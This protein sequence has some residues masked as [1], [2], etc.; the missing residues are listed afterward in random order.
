V[1]GPGAASRT[2]QA[3]LAPAQLLC[4]AGLACALSPL[5]LGHATPLAGA[6]ATAAAGIGGGY[7]AGIARLRLAG[8]RGRRAAAL[9][10]GWA[11]VGFVLARL[12]HVPP[13][14]ATWWAI[15]GFAFAIQ[16]MGTAL[17][18]TEESARALAARTVLAGAAAVVFAAFRGPGLLP[19]PA[20]LALAGLGAAAVAHASARALYRGVEPSRIARSA[21]AVV[22][23]LAALTLVLVLTPVLGWIAAGLQDLLALFGLAVAAVM[24]PL[25]YGLLWL[26]RLF[27][28]PHKPFKPTASGPPH[29][30]H[31][32]TGA[33]V[34]HPVAAHVLTALVLAGAAL[35]VILLVARARRP[36]APVDD[37]LYRDEF[38]PP[39][40]VRRRRRA[41]PAAP[42]PDGVR[43]A[44]A[45]ALG[46]LAQASDPRLQ[47]APAETPARVLARV[48]AALGDASP[49][50]QAFARLTAA[51]AAARYARANERLDGPV[52]A[53]ARALRAVV[54][55]RAA[56]A[57]RG[58]G[59]S[60]GPDARPTP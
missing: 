41:A 19:A 37:T 38:L 3:L 31:T 17:V 36:A 43:R 55:T 50:V 29:R 5:F 45:L 13:G 44:Y 42:P 56:A 15:A 35:A 28:H 32:L 11:A 8:E 18:E 59:A 21:G 22:A 47:P 40:A 14:S 49:A 23:V 39:D 46:V 57:R 6:V 34:A 27:A 30:G 60:S 58:R 4:L 33:Q 9:A 24:A 48:R 52:Q 1:S 20:A 25:A 10:V 53:T 7:L 2:V 51:Y 12:L 26:F 54:P 16:G